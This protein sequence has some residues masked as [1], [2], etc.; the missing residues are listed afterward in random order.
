M[1]QNTPWTPEQRSRKKAKLD[2]EAAKVAGRVGA[3]HVIVIAFFPEGEFYHM[4]DGGSSPVPMKQLYSTML[5]TH[6][7]L[8][9]SGGEDI[10]TQ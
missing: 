10:A 1:S 6:M 7:K 8:E 2:K 9:L 4:M 5:A 3:D